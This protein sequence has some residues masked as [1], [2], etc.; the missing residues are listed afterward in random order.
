MKF[1]LPDIDLFELTMVAILGVSAL[2]VVA[3]VIGTVGYMAGFDTV[4]HESDYSGHAVDLEVEKGLV[5]QT[6]QVHMKTNP[7]SSEHE[8][9]CVHPDNHGQLDQIRTA[10]SNGHRMTVSYYRPLWVSPFDCEQGTSV[11]TNVE[12]HEEES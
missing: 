6:T 4:R 9:F 2:L 1:T 10:V 3:T 8:T 11:I 12:I 7:R 5:F